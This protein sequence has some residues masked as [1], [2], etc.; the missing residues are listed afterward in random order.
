MNYPVGK[1]WSKSLRDETKQAISEMRISIPDG[2]LH[3]KNSDGRKAFMSI[4]DLMS[5][6]AQ[7]T[8]SESGVP[9]SFKS[10][11]ALIDAGWVID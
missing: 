2:R 6:V 9:L 5:E 1:Q 4:Q 7:L 3:F 8:D 11:D 10:T